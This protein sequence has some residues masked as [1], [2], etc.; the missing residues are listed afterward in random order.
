MRLT[1]GLKLIITVTSPQY[2]LSFVRF[3]QFVS[4][5]SGHKCFHIYCVIIQ[6]GQMSFLIIELMENMIHKC[7]VISSSSSPSIEVQFSPQKIA[8][9]LSMSNHGTLVFSDVE[10]LPTKL[11][12]VPYFA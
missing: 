9:D 1:N 11:W 7:L 8:S 6:P 12:E 2:S 3:L 10:M 5:Y 4:V